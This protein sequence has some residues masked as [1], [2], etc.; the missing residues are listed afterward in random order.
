MCC[1]I[2]K[3]S[4]KNELTLKKRNKN[5]LNQRKIQ[6]SSKIDEITEILF[7]YINEHHRV[8]N[9]IFQWM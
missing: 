8:K 4:I 1:S 2:Y 7:R 6:N 3:L 5:K 9:Q